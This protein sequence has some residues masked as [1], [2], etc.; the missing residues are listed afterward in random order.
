MYTLQQIYD[1]LTE[2]SN[3]AKRV[4]AFEEP[5]KPPSGVSSGVTLNQ[6]MQA[7]PKHDSVHGARANDVRA[8]KKYWS[9]NVSGGGPW[10]T[11]NGT[12]AER[13]FLATTTIVSNGFY[14]VTNL[15]KVDLDLA[16]SNI[17]ANAEIF[18]VPGDANVVNTSSGNATTNDIRSGK[19]AWVNGVCVTGTSTRTLSP[20][21]TVV[22]AG[23]YA[24]TNLTQVDVHLAPSNILA[25][26]EIFGVKGDANVVDTGSGNA[27]SNDIR[28]GRIAWA[29]GT[30][31]TGSITNEAILASTD[32]VPAGFYVQT[33]LSDVDT[34]L[35]ASN[36]IVGTTIFGVA[37][38]HILA[39]I[40]APVLKTG[41]TN[42]YLVGD[43]G[44][45]E[46]GA[47]ERTP[48]F[49]SMPT[50]INGKTHTVVKDR[51]TELMWL[52]DAMGTPYSTWAN[53]LNECATMSYAGYSDWRLPNV[54]ELASLLD[55]GSYPLLVVDKG[56]PF[57]A[58]GWYY[59]TS[60]TDP[61]ATNFAYR[62]YVEDGTVDSTLK[63]YAS[64]SFWP[65]RGGF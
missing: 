23:Y 34:D 63:T 17:L 41:Q 51:V 49:R 62:V 13:Q 59:W 32:N 1:R 42:C 55:Y 26:V 64:H 28:I 50:N 53:A 16:T 18:G 52:Q 60:T 29:N 48:R 19:I 14:A 47:A 4:T 11:T 9:L 45:Y 10:G 54:N 37:G 38:T 25:N 43:D 65:V 15:T 33:I 8:G 57:K 7:C 3:T 39:P 36:I 12:G 35:Q 56:K 24:A 61:A 5:T 20:T 40:P 6:V 31:I 46:A 21:T 30:K 22:A 27:T 44:H 2:G 58:G